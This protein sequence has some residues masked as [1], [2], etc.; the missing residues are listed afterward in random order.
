MWVPEPTGVPGVPVPV[1]VPVPVPVGAGG[2]AAGGV[3]GVV[4]GVPFGAGVPDPVQAGSLEA[5]G[6]VGAEQGVWLAVDPLVVA[7]PVVAP[8]PPWPAV[9]ESDPLGFC[10]PA[11][12][13]LGLLARVGTCEAGR[14]GTAAAGSG[15]EGDQAPVA[16]AGG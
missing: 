2:V 10:A 8:V 16:A 7:A 11:M 14:D 3:E 6:S 5:A 13:P 15:S 12:P 4:P 1:T 9:V